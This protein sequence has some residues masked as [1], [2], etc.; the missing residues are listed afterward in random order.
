MSNEQ[1]EMSPD[2][3]YVVTVMTKKGSP[4]GHH[5]RTWGFERTFELA[6]EK[7]LENV[8]DLFE[9][10][11]VYAVIEHLNPGVPSWGYGSRV[12]AWYKANYEPGNVRVEKLT[13]TPE[14]YQ[15]YME[16]AMG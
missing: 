16:F 2:G 4:L 9:Y 14:E 3:I 6:E 13:E 7:I 11:Y 5:Q 12:C 1:P 8:S 15:G 10:L